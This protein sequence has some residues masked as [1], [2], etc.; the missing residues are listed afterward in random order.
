[1]QCEVIG[2]GIAAQR[3]GCSLRTAHRLFDKGEL[4]GYRIGAKKVIFADAIEKFQTANSNIKE[5]KKPAPVASPER[6]DKVK[7]HETVMP[8]RF[9][10]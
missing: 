1:M 5:K 9:L 7:H 3:L 8:F 10:H 6:A 2:L 4:E